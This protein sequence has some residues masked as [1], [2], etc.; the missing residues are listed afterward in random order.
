MLKFDAVDVYYG[1]HHVL[2]QVNYVVYPHEI[3]CLLGGN[4]SGKSTTMKTIL[5]VVRP[6]RGT[7]EFNGR[8]IDQWET[9]DRVRA[10][11]AAVPEA[12]RVFPELSVMDNL[13][14]GAYVRHRRADLAQD[15]DRVFGMFPRLAERRHQLAG[16]MSGG[17]QQM[18]AIGRALMARPQLICM[19]EPSMGLAPKL[20]QQVFQIIQQ[21]QQ[22]GVTVF[23]VEQNAHAALG[24]ADRGYVLQTGRI[25]LADRASSLLSNPE[26]RTAYLGET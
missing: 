22:Q 5:G 2:Q 9:G 19:D 15:F 7:V 1:P 3:V 4:A 20:V 10:G 13:E 11:I 8:R 16:T 18:L 24:I 14:L 23:L 6:R 25:V 12:R 21:L 17:E 26:I